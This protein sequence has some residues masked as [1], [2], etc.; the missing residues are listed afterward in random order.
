MDSMANQLGCYLQMSASIE[1]F[2]QVTSSLEFSGTK[3][4]PDCL[5]APASFWMDV[6]LAGSGRAPQSHVDPA[7]WIPL[8]NPNGACTLP[9]TITRVFDQN[10][11]KTSVKYLTMPKAVAS[12]YGSLW[13]TAGVFSSRLKLRR[14]IKRQYLL[15][16]RAVQT[17]PRMTWGLSYT[18]RSP[19]DLSNGSAPSTGHNCRSCFLAVVQP[20]PCSSSISKDGE[21]LVAPR[22]SLLSLASPR[23][24]TSP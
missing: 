11:P 4:F 16:P 19:A 15:Q 13:D 23:S 17:S 20:T 12:L 14:S 5:Q 3:P 10:S 7:F 21:S 9:V 18:P 1:S 2:L 6:W 8:P 22:V 24:T